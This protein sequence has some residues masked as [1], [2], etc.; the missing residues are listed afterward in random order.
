MG[1]S[2]E[3]S[4]LNSFPALDQNHDAI[5]PGCIWN[6]VGQQALKEYFPKV[7]GGVVGVFDDGTVLSITKISTKLII[8]L[9]LNKLRYIIL[10]YLGNVMNG[11]VVSIYNRKRHQN[12]NTTFLNVF[13]EWIGRLHHTSL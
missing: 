5:A 3:A 7:R 13:F 4:V 6:I 9:E 11:S 8:L 1:Q 12:A 10:R 2:R